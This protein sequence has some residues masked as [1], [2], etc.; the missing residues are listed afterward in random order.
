[1]QGRFSD[2]ERRGDRG[3]RGRACRP[4]WRRGRRSR[5]GRARRRQD[6]VRARRLPRARRH[7]PGHQPD[8]HDRPALPRRRCPSPTSTCS[9]FRASP[10]RIQICSPTTSGPTR[11]RSSS[12]RRGA[13]TRSARWPGSQPAWC[14]SS[15]P[16]AIGAIDGDERTRAGERPRLRHRDRAPR[17]SRWSGHRPATSSRRATTR[18]RASDRARHQAAAADRRGCSSARAVGWEAVDRIAVGVGPG[19]FTGLRIGV[20]TARALAQAGADP[21]GRRLDTR[22][23]RR[24]GRRGRA[25]RGARRRPRGTRRPP[26]RGVRRRPGGCRRIRRGPAAAARRRAALAPEALADGDPRSS[27]EPAGDR[28]RRARIQGGS[29][30]SGAIVPA[31]D[32]ELHRVSA[33]RP[34]P[35]GARHRAGRPGPGGPPRVPPPPRRRDSP[36][37]RRQDQ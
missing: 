23:A 20:A 17:R 5:A 14:G 31:D 27:A 25:D 28:G 21:A 16:G 37:R 6:D 4:I 12:G 30:A 3:D 26:R 33:L 2:S 34:L 11:S 9:A 36:S 22:V 19:T 29:R 10:A 13:R 35:A 1:M 18:R 15:T 8:L 32:S 7:R 24:S